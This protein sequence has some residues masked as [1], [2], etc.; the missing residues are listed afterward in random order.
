M[1]RSIAFGAD[2]EHGRPR[3]VPAVVSGTG[4]SPLRSPWACRDGW[5]PPPPDERGAPVSQ[6]RH[7]ALRPGSSMFW[8]SAPRRARCSRKWLRR[9]SGN[10]GAPG[11]APRGR[12]LAGAPSSHRQG[13]V[14]WRRSA[15]RWLVAA[16]VVM[17]AP[18]AARGRGDDEEK[19]DEQAA[20][21]HDTSSFGGESR[22]FAAHIE[23]EDG[24]VPGVINATGVPPP[25]GPGER[26]RNEWRGSELGRQLA[27]RACRVAR[28]DLVRRCGA[29]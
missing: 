26:R 8:F 4:A 18:A 14:G 6:G 12:A 29:L 27:V 19:A 25:P 11:R 3:V 23:A 13:R 17:A 21:E 1:R 7:V 2:A 5:G 16:A 28:P 15:L 10:R 24:P 20:R 9:S 22:S